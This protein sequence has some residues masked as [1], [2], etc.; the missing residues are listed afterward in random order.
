MFRS[1]KTA[2]RRSFVPHQLLPTVAEPEGAT[3]QIGQKTTG[4]PKALRAKQ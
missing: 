1:L 3:T 2:L 4:A